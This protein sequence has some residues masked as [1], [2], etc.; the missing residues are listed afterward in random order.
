MDWKEWKSN[1]L[2]FSNPKR[3]IGKVKW[4]TL[5]WM[6]PGA[7]VKISWRTKQWEHLDTTT[8]F[9]LKLSWTVAAVG[10]IFLIKLKPVRKWWVW[11]SVC[12]NKYM[13]SSHTAE[14]HAESC[15]SKIIVWD[16]WGL[17]EHQSQAE[18]LL[19]VVLPCLFLLHNSVELL[20][21]KKMLFCLTFKNNFQHWFMVSDLREQI[22]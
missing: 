21:T 14:G 1:K 13:S 20:L 11:I 5:H 17:P 3:S 19:P 7:R 2:K 6:Q 18:S 10:I 8:S 9:L 12:F 16:L 4:K 22:L 15:K